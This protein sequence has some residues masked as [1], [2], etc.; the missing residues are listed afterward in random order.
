LFTSPSRLAYFVDVSV[1]FNTS[2][3]VTDLLIAAVDALNNTG[4]AGR[5]SIRP[6]V[7]YVAFYRVA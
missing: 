1:N 3:D 4:M 7:K 5:K 2:F 6:A